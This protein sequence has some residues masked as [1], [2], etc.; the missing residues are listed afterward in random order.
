MNVAPSLNVMQAHFETGVTHSL[1]WRRAQLATLERLLRENEKPIFAAL[2]K[3]LGKSET[4]AFATELGL[5]YAELR[6]TKT[7]LKRW[8]RNTRLWPGLHN[9]PAR[10]YL[11]PQPLGV[12][13]IIAPWNYPLM[14]ALGPL[15]GA[16][17]AGNCAVVK[18]SEL[19]PETSALIH[20][21]VDQYFQ[22]AAVKVVEGAVPE[23]TALLQQGFDHIFF[24]GSEAVG[25]IVM[26]AAADHLTPVTL[27]LGGKSPC[28][29]TPSADMKTAVRRIAWGK[30]LNAGQTCVAPDYVLALPGTSQAFKAAFAKEIQGFFGPDPSQSPDYPR[31]VGQGHFDRLTAMMSADHVAFGGQ[32]DPEDLYIAPTLLENLPESSAALNEEIFGPILP[33]IEVPDLDAAIAHINARPK[34]LALYAFT[35]QRSE[36][37]RIEAE[38]SSGS[39]VFNEVVMQFGTTSLPFGGVGNSGM[40]LSHGKASFDT[41]SHRKPVL[42][43]PNWGEIKLRYAPYKP[44]QLKLLR[45]FFGG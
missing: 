37:A 29:L 19:T 13:L 5:L 26:R 28:I 10:A 41:F 45:R 16:L 20:R 1:Q 32:S 18:P 36:Q 8:M 40:G 7:H 3:D 33:I 38:T 30:S 21:L 42:R 44:A 12:V 39:A 17:A 31:I 35:T 15:I 43:K 2:H 22:P 34:P 27:E 23:T 4:E 6:H 24:T 14:L 11:T 25:K 9:M